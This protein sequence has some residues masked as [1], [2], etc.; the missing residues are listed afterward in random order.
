MST[1]GHARRAIPILPFFFVGLI[2]Y[3]DWISNK[4]TAVAIMIGAV[5]SIA[6]MFRDQLIDRVGLRPYLD[7]L[8]TWARAILPAIPALILVLARGQGTANAGGTVLLASVLVMVATV[9]FRSQIDAKLAG[10]YKKR[11]RIL[12]RF[13]RG[14]LVAIVPILAGFLIVHGSL[15]DIPA[16]WGAVTQHAAS[17]AGR[18]GQIFFATI[19][20]AAL[21][22][23]LMAEPQGQSARASAHI[24]P[25]G[26]LAA[27]ASPD[28]SAQPIA[29]LA[30]G[31]RVSI[32]QQD[33]AWAHVQAEN[34]W[35]GWVDARRLIPEPG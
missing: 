3:F 4:Q 7:R 21:G 5:G 27:W 22:Y 2:A 9:G 8:P 31:V 13:A 18:G 14:I 1:A 24:V 11:D 12:P 20:S 23:V 10:F 33:G 32:T 15:K 25:A 35:T 29:Q 6:I 17:P 30:Q 26:G 19:V 28:P 16:L 34:G